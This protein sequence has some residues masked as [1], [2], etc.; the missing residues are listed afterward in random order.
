MNLSD[1]N[2]GLQHLS[3]FSG[4][5]RVEAISNTYTTLSISSKDSHADIERVRENEKE[6]EE[7]I[8]CFLTDVASFSDV[9]HYS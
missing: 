1:C 4:M 9:S 2:E 3:V 8:V 6:K 5:C 7:G